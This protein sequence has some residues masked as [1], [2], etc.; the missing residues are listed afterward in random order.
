MS[1]SRRGIKRIPRYACFRATACQISGSR[2]QLSQ[3]QD[4]LAGTRLRTAHYVRPLDQH[5]ADLL[6]AGAA[7][8]FD[9]FTQL[10][11]YVVKSDLASAL[12]APPYRTVVKDY[13]LFF[14]PSFCTG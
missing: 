2:R 12:C 7:A 13:F 10:D 1:G 11:G 5:S 6:S 14:S 4:P 9:D 3:N 8:I